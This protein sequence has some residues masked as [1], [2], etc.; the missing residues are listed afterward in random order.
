LQQLLNASR[1]EV[2]ELPHCPMLLRA[3]I[4][5]MLCL[6][7]ASSSCWAS[8][9][10]CFSSYSAFPRAQ[11]KSFYFLVSAI[12]LVSLSTTTS[13]SSTIGACMS[14]SPTAFSSIK[15]QCTALCPAACFCLLGLGRRELVFNGLRERPNCRQLFDH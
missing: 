10:H 7:R 12:G 5:P 9:C 2:K 8:S 11:S 15:Q 14:G 6:R 1:L 3:E 4:A 13:P